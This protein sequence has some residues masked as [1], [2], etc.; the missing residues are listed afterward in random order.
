MRV[1][2][3]SRTVDQRIASIRFSY[4]EN[5][6]FH[7]S[8]Q[9]EQQELECIRRGDVEGLEA[10][11]AVPDTGKPGELSKDPLRAEKNLGIC[12]LT[13]NCRAAIQGGVLP[14]EAFSISDAY[15]QEME[16]CVRISDVRDLIREAK[17]RYAELVAKKVAESERNLLVEGCKNYIFQNMHRKIEAREIANSL[18]VAPGY[19]SQVFHRHTGYTIMQYIMK[20]KTEHCGN[21]LRYSQYTYEEIAYYFGF[22]SQSHF[23]KVFKHWMGITPRQ[24]R[25]RYS[26][27]EQDSDELMSDGFAGEVCFV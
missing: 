14:E 22:C 1:N 7:N 10:L 17:F 3:M 21:L 25:E 15:I 13:G 12:A 19:L 4:Q 8:Y 23:G 27:K 18:H 5:E 26:V 24:Y 16:E 11:E 9:R 2:N 20:E 6:I